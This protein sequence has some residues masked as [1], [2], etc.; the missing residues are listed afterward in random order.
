MKSF[1]IQNGIDGKIKAFTL[2][3]VLASL[4]IVTMVILGPLTSA[5]NSS[6]YARQT[7]DVMVSTYLAEEALELLHYQYNTLYLACSSSVDA[8]SSR[9]DG[10]TPGE[11]AWK[12]F[13]TRLNDD[14]S[15][16]GLVSCFSSDGTGGCSYD[17]L[18]MMDA[19]SATP[20]KKYSPTGEDCSQLS[21]VTSIVTGIDGVRNYF[22][23]SGIGIS[24]PRLVDNALSV[25]KKTYSRRV[26]VVSVPTFETSCGIDAP[27]SA[28]YYD[29]LIV[30]VHISFKRPNQSI[31][32]ITVTDFFHAR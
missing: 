21:M 13:K 20:P 27:H 23:C 17:F 14:T 19:T 32:T 15:A 1:F 30:T 22:V 2:L 4:T 5:I 29:D 3:E 8:C 28:C 7:K 12:L 18:D 24:S 11:Q 6:S 25:L 26:T 16:P 31:R 10:L 9:E